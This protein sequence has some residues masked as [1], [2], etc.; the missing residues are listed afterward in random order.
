MQN[1]IINVYKGSSQT[2][3]TRLDAKISDLS[4]N[5]HNAVNY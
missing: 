1:P 5:V 4:K 3:K 2:L